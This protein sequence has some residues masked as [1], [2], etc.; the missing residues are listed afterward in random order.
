[1]RN[2]HNPPTSAAF[3]LSDR[4]IDRLQRCACGGLDAEH[5]F[6]LEARFVGR[7]NFLNGLVR[8]G[9]IRMNKAQDIRGFAD[10]VPRSRPPL[11]GGLPG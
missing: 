6:L 10:H 7:D 1:M 2:W 3:A 9:I 11:T 4:D 5:R 8:H